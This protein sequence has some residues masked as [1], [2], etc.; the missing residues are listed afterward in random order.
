[1]TL[2]LTELGWCWLLAR[3]HF[4]RGSKPCLPLGHLRAGIV[5]LP[6]RRLPDVAED[7]PPPLQSL[8]SQNPRMVW[9]R[10]DLSV[11]VVPTPAVGRDVSHSGAALKCRPGTLLL[12]SGGSP[13][14]CGELQ[15]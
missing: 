7:F 4:P 2:A 11:R 9:V 12:S 15:T 6:F 14:V 3:I 1:M 8:K 5:L 10:R 13:G